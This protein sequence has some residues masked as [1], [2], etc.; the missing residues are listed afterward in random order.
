[1]A[2]FLLSRLAPSHH[3]PAEVQ[4]REDPSLAARPDVVMGLRERFPRSDDASFY[5]YCVGVGY[6]EGWLA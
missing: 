1:M 4:L 2:R 5:Q 3:D 6:G